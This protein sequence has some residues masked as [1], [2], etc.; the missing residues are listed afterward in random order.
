MNYEFYD[1]NALIYLLGRFAE[2]PIKAASFANSR[3]IVISNRVLSEIRISYSRNSELA[4]FLLLADVYIVNLDTLHFWEHDNVSSNLGARQLFAPDKLLPW[5][6]EFMASPEMQNIIGADISIKE[7]LYNNYVENFRTSAGTMLHEHRL[8]ASI[9]AKIMQ[10]AAKE[11]RLLSPDKILYKHFPSRFIIEY[12]WYYKYAKQEPSNITANDLYDVINATAA[13][14]VDIWVGERSMG[15]I[16]KQI[17]NHAF[18]TSYSGIKYLH[19]KGELSDAT[20]ASL[21]RMKDR[22]RIQEIGLEDT[23]ILTLRNFDELYQ[24]F[25]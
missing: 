17:K 1:T 7:E 10:W 25:K 11:G 21:A 8:R 20:F 22:L 3:K 19:K 12:V 23:K 18:P 4:D 5:T 14:Y 9:D 2:D 13:P 16:L 15:G 24:K 6:V